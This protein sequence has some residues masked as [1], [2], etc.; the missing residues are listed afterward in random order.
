L[1]VDHAD[2]AGVSERIEAFLDNRP[3]ARRTRRRQPRPEVARAPAR[4]RKLDTRT[5]WDAA[6]LHEDARVARYGRPVS[7]LVVG[8]DLASSGTPDHLAPAIG[9]A[10]RSAAR[11]TDRVARVGPGRFH[12]LLPE[13]EEAEAAAVAERIRMTCGD[14][15]IHVAS[16]S[17]SRGQ[18]L[19]DALAL[20]IARVDRSMTNGT[21]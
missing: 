4:P 14:H 15:P 6:L 7:V 3:P 12:I 18:T 8:L 21:T 13:T 20:A 17:P 9:I 2:D 19:I 1:P 10:I 16:A 5:D 11:E